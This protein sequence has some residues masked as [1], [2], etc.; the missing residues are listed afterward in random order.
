MD[1]NLS[2][3]SGA[4]DIIDSLLTQNTNGVYFAGTAGGSNTQLKV[5]G[6]QLTSLT[7]DAFNL[8]N[9]A[10]G[11]NVF[12]T[13]SGSRIQGVANAVTLQNSAADANTR[14]YVE[15]DSSQAINVANAIDTNATNG[16]KSYAVVRDS[17][18]RARQRGHQDSRDLR[19]G[20]PHPVA[21]EQLHDRRR[22]RS[23]R[24]PPRRLAHRQVQPT[25]S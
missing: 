13:V 10:I 6:S 3:A 8:S 9:S 24:R 17:T 5:A 16:G 4:L 22:S 23:G 12:L 18:L 20:Q 21:G 1:A 25:I 11:R 19:L 14:M 7:N 2:G 15:M